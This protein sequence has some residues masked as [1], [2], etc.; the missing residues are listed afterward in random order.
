M[1]YRVNQGTV[2]ALQVAAVD[3]A[4]A[5]RVFRA[6]AAGG[7]GLRLA[8]LPSDDQLSGVLAELGAE[9]AVRQHEMLLRLA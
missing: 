1:I 6:A 3:E 9:V 7:A 2:I 8:N 5:E 4:S